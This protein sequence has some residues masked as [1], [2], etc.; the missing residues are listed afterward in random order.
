MDIDFGKGQRSPVDDPHF[1]LPDQI[2][3]MHLHANM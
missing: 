3:I 2:N 1:L